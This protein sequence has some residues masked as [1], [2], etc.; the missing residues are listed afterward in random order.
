MSVKKTRGVA[1]R[2][3]H[4]NF[5]ILATPALF[6]FCLFACGFVPGRGIKPVGRGVMDNWP[7]V[8]YLSESR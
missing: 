2:N 3:T 1:L 4:V 7:A 6:K 8:V 5:S